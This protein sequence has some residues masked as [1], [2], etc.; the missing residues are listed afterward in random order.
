ME[1]PILITGCARSGTSMTSGIIEICGAF[2]GQMLMG[3]GRAN[4]KGFF[5]NREIRENIM[6][7]YLILNGADPLGQ[8]PL[9]D[10]HRL[11]PLANLQERIEGIITAEGYKDGAWFY[12]GAKMS[13][14]WPTFDHAFPDAK[15]VIVRR[16]DEDI[17]NSCL[18][19]GFMRAHRDV[20]GW[21]RW[22]DHHKER[23]EAMKDAGLNVREVWPSKFVNG[24]YSE[25]RDVIEH[26]GLEWKEDAVKEFVSPKLW[27]E[28]N[29]K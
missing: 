26:L 1:S 2:G 19:T 11:L 9:P 5:E 20:K 17:A 6:K 27:R 3:H 8:D 23:F 24:D 18:R 21:L 15:W 25:I 16:N 10:P 13:L 22:I 12:K 29:G 7:P 28:T 14:I 4:Q